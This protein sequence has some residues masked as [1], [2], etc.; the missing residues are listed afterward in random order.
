MVAN[1]FTQPPPPPHN[2][3]SYGPEVG[4]IILTTYFEHIIN[5]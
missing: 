4:S 1:I 3:A 5:S 2:K